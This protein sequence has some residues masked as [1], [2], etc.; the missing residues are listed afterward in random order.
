MLQGRQGPSEFSSL[1]W[2]PAPTKTWCAPTLFSAT[3]QVVG[4]LEEVGLGFECRHGCR[5]GKA[6][7]GTEEQTVSVSE[8]QQGSGQN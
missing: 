1:A 3:D 2:S 5:S 8:A 6:G 7:Q 4:L